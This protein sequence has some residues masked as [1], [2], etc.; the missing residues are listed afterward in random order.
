MGALTGIASDRWQA[1]PCHSQRLPHPRPCGGS[2][3][4]HYCE[5]RAP[6]ANSSSISRANHSATTAPQSPI[7]WQSCFLNFFFFT[8]SL[9]KHLKLERNN[10]RHKPVTQKTCVCLVAPAWPPNPQPPQAPC[11]AGASDLSTALLTTHCPRQQGSVSPEG[12]DEEKA[13]RI[14]LLAEGQS[15]NPPTRLFHR[16]GAAAAHLLQLREAHGGGWGNKIKVRPVSPARAAFP[17]PEVAQPPPVKPRAV[18]GA[19]YGVQHLLRTARDKSETCHWGGTSL[20]HLAHASPS[21]SSCSPPW[22]PLLCSS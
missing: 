8:L 4:P 12:T 2:S 20:S 1:A 5:S 18:T 13:G 11:L 21:V 15:W 9:K 14:K 6:T 17:G 3:V 10:P 19:L 22:D 7:K 16:A